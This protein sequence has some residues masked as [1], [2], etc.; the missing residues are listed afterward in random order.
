MVAGKSDTIIVWKDIIVRDMLHEKSTVKKYLTV[1][2]TIHHFVDTNTMVNSAIFNDYYNTRI[3]HVA[4]ADSLFNVSGSDTVKENRLRQSNL[5]LT[6]KG[7][8]KEVIIKQTEYK[9]SLRLYFTG[10]LTFTGRTINDIS[11]GLVLVGKNNLFVGANYGLLSKDIQFT[12]GY[13]L[14]GK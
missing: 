11:P 4:F 7:K 14:L 5:I 1:H 9:Q 6:Y 13:R 3:Y 8:S 2:D 12:L 10:S